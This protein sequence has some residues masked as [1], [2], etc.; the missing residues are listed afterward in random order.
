M[1]DEWEQ[2][3]GNLPM[4]AA[5]ARFLPVPHFPSAFSSTPVDVMFAC[6]H[7]SSGPKAAPQS[8][9]SESNREGLAIC[10]KN[11]AAEGLD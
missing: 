1:D 3:P 4:T 9:T 8:I 11:T 6:S 7:N 5:E 2:N 10:T